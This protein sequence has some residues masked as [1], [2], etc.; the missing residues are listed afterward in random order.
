M[1]NNYVIRGD[2]A[3]IFLERKDGKIIE[4]IIDKDDLPIAQ[5]LPGKWFAHLEHG[6]FYVV[7]NLIIPGGRQFV[8]LYRWITNCQPGLQVD[9]INHDTLNNTRS[10]LRNVSRLLNQQNRLLYK[11]NKSG[12]AGIRWDKKSNKWK[13]EFKVNSKAIYVGCFIDK[14]QALK[15]L[16]EAKINRMQRIYMDD[17]PTPCPICQR[18]MDYCGVKFEEE[19]K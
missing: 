1:K 5:K 14:E 19:L 2:Q 3:I 9:H 11:N 8:R 12:V 7:G 15:A 16:H 6:S 13:V 18:L 10:N 17:N 4:T